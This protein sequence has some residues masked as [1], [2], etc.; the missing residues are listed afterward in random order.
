MPLYEQS[1]QRTPTTTA[2]TIIKEWIAKYGVPEAVLSDNGKEFRSK[3]W[4]AVCE[5]LDIER[6]H[7]VPYHPECNGNSEK[8][9]GTMKAMMRAYVDE[10][11]TNW[12]E[13]LP[14][15]CF[16]YNT[17]THETTKETPFTICH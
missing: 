16:A 17:S 1:R 15:L 14:L 12:D 2:D 11:Q 10:N 3:V 5:L 4:D 8:N 7:T 6:L 9:V 13:G